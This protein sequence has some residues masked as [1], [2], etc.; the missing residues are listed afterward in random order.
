LDSVQAAVLDVK[1]KYL[2][3]YI[4]SRQTAANFYDNK[5]MNVDEL[6]IPA[7]HER[8]SHVF[9]QYTLITENIVRDELRSLLDEEDISSA[10]YYPV[11]IHLQDA[12]QHLGYKKGD[13]PVTEQLSETVISLPIHTEMDLALLQYITERVIENVKKLNV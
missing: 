6:K 4:V 3:D 13:L 2:D 7:R 9:H 1:L 12:Y 8:S 11:P 10:V 5:F